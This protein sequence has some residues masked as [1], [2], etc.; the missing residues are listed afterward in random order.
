MK[1]RDVF[2]ATIRFEKK[3][4]QNLDFEQFKVALEEQ[5]NTLR[6]DIYREVKRKKWLIS[7]KK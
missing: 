6:N 4:L 2:L 7:V 1:N 3:G 5:L